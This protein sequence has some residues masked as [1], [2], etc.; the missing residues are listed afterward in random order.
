MFKHLLDEIKGFKYQITLK[1][2]LRKHKENGEI[3]FAPVYFN[4][5]TKAMM[6]SKYDLDKFFQKIL[7]R[8]DNWINEGSGRVIESI[9]RGCISISIFS[10]LSVSS[11]IE[12][13]NKLRNSKKL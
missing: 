6:N 8:I 10:P 9:N 11:Y 5:T 13:Y 3:E 7:Y 4:Y 12:L 1:I 2:L